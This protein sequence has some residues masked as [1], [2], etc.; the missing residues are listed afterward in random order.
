M[1]LPSNET[2]NLFNLLN[3][4]ERNAL[5]NCVFSYLKNKYGCAVNTLIYSGNIY[6]ENIEWVGGMN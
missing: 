4:E 2:I 5:T 6:V 3:N 1:E